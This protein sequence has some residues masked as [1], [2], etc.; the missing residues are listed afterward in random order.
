MINFASCNTSPL[1]AYVPTPENPWD[2]IKVR[3]LHK[4]LSFGVNFSQ[5][6]NALSST[7]SAYIDQL[8]DETIALPYTTPPAWANLDPA[9]YPANGLTYSEE[10]NDKN[11]EETQYAFIKE[12]LDN[13]VRGRITLFWHNILVTRAVEYRFAGYAYR[14][15]L[16]LQRNCLGNFKD[17]IHEI[18]LDEAMLKFL[19]GFENT[20][21]SPNENYAREL[22]ELFTLGEG[23]GYTEDDI[24]ETARALTG[25][26]DY[27]NGENSRIVFNEANFDTDDKTIFGQTGNWGYD[28]VIDIL[29]AQK[30][31]LIARFICENVYENFVSPE[32]DDQIRL[33]IINPLAD[34]FIADN[35]NIATLFKTLLKSE[36]F[37]DAEARNVIIK[38]P[39]DLILEFMISSGL[40][41][42]TWEMNKESVKNVARLFDQDI[43]NPPTVAGWDGDK[44]WI[45]SGTITFRGA[46][47]SEDIIFWAFEQNE[48]QFRQF[49]KDVSTDHTDAEI[50]TKAIFAAI[51]GEEPYSTPDIEVGI[52]I[53]KS[54]VPSN[55]FEQAIWSLDF[56]SAPLQVR[57]LL[58]YIVNLPDNQL[59]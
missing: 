42:G 37:F 52:D 1:T 6:T 47:L 19:N 8:I 10:E 56:V 30:S 5:L 44:A 3:H 35:Y 43:L 2:A 32:I 49:A 53:F 34:I 25:Y 26:N 40:D 14:Y 24:V 57:D 18:G 21:G 55:Y 41:F 50:V 16:T 7:P 48:E 33:L 59:K 45:N 4:R 15:F 9:N 51:L 20:A 58:E 17:F 11:V 27:S 22:Y 36:H 12:C 38:S 31:T 28:D 23:N 39:L 29:F 13:G 46:Y 54:R